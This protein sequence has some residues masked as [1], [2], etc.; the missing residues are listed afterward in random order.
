MI[1]YFRKRE[2]RKVREL[3]SGYLNGSLSQ[4]DMERVGCH[5]SRC[6]ECLA[7]FRSLKETVELLH[8][9]P[10]EIASPP[11][12][13]SEADRRIPAPKS[14]MRKLSVPASIILVLALGAWAA[15]LNFG[16][17]QETNLPQSEEPKVEMVAEDSNL[18]GK[19]APPTKVSVVPLAD[20]EGARPVPVKELVA[21]KKT[22]LDHLKPE[23]GSSVSPYYREI[24][25]GNFIL[26]F[27]YE[28]GP[29]PERRE[30]VSPGRITSLIAHLQEIC[31]CSPLHMPPGQ[32]SKAL[33]ERR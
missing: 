13:I 26:G 23:Q 24:K 33:K 2:C 15:L 6:E 31:P 5:L 20:K 4:S 32:I 1:N 17:E 30:G 22:S 18:E 25:L 3:L 7:E 11:F 14:W 8:R 29:P 27:G 16:G 19:E 21:E 10:S 12:F 9:L 28:G